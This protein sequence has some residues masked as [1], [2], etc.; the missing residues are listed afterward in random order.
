MS[1]DCQY[2]ILFKND[3]YEIHCTYCP[4]IGL[5]GRMEW[6][7]HLTIIDNKYNKRYHYGYKRNISNN[8]VT[9]HGIKDSWP[10]WVKNWFGQ[11]GENDFFI[12]KC[13]GAVGMY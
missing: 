7:N 12:Q 2:N 13:G 8:T 9:W 6:W 11:V 5:M 1:T 3:R 10:V 4:A